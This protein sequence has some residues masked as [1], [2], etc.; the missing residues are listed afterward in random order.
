[1]QESTQECCSVSVCVWG[2]GGHGLYCSQQVKQGKTSMNRNCYSS[3]IT[4]CMP[5]QE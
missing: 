2:G 4:T 1:M 5:M 3:N